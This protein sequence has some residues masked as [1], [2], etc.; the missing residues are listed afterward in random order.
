MIVIKTN[1][2]QLTNANPTLSLRVGVVRS[3]WASRSSKSVSGRVASRGGFDSHPFP[4]NPIPQN[5]SEHHPCNHNGI[6]VAIKHFFWKLNMTSKDLSLW[7][8]IT[9]K[10]VQGFKSL[11]IFCIFTLLLRYSCYMVYYL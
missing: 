9:S 10:S 5:Q 1:L 4:S 2:N 7:T 11:A 6:S 8:I 3:R